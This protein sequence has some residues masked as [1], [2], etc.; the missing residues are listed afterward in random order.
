VIRDDEN[1]S[2]ACVP[3]TG[4]PSCAVD[5]LLPASSRGCD[6]DRVALHL[7]PIG[8]GCHSD[9]HPTHLH[10]RQ[11]FPRGRNFLA[12]F[13]PV[14]PAASTSVSP[15]AP[16]PAPAAAAAASP[17]LLVLPPR[18]RLALLLRARLAGAL[19][20]ATAATGAGVA[21]AEA[22]EDESTD[23]DEEG[24]VGLV[25]R[26]VVMGP[27]RAAP[28]CVWWG[29]G[30]AG[31]SLLNLKA[32]LQTSPRMSLAR[33]PVDSEAS[34]RGAPTLAWARPPLAC[35]SSHAHA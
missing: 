21:A 28:V 18:L 34:D 22:G 32:L 8:A 12:P 35:E 29:W 26:S 25:V 7:W 11:T 33:P 5:F 6:V 13:P 3:F 4:G 16:A 20:A 15:P 1:N 24:S 17:S 10:C 27:R 23:D 9:T 14:A 19:K 2:H 30:T 31:V